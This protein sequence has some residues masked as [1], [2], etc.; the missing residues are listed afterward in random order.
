[1]STQQRLFT[2]KVSNKQVKS[3]KLSQAWRVKDRGSEIQDVNGAFKVVNTVKMMLLLPS[4][5]CK[6]SIS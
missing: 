2:D 3:D 1:M 5:Y 6:S 4:V